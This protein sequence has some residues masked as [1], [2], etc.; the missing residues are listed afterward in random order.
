MGQRHHRWDVARERQGMTTPCITRTCTRM[1][2]PGISRC[3]PC[4]ATRR[5]TG[6]NSPEYRAL[7]KPT[8]PCELRL[9]V[10][11]GRATSWHHLIPLARGGNHKRDNVI[12]ACIACNSSKRDR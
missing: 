1:A 3:R 5:A 12:P 4:E 10:C 9:R 2:R 7:P 6:Y 8:G 11:T